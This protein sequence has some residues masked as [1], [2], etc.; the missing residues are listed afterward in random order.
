MVKK[1]HVDGC[2][3]AHAL[4]LV[5]D[6]WALLVVR[7]LLLGPKRF[8]D[9]RAGLPNISPN[10]L[11]QRLEDLEKSAI[12]VRR[13]LPPPA[14]AWVYELT[15]WGQGLEPVIMAL[16]RWAVRSPF[17]PQGTLNADALI[18]SMRTMF[19][20]SQDLDGTIE[21]R[22]GDETFHASLDGGRMTLVRGSVAEPD[23][24][25]EGPP[26]AIAGVAYMGAKSSALRI[27]GDKNLAKRFLAS[28][29]LPERIAI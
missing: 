11:T 1:K 19:N 9:L 21:L 26:E 23:A 25:I 2:A 8:T 28:F 13:R 10:V 3:A 15:E 29:P 24:V 18:L 5:G 20:G 4:D 17:L 12:V 27:E 6:R 22:I 7:Q 14:S 16:G